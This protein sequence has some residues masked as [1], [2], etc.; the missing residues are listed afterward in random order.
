[1]TP[2]HRYLSLIRLFKFDEKPISVNNDDITD[3]VT[4]DWILNEAAAAK[5]VIVI[6]LQVWGLLNWPKPIH[7]RVCIIWFRSDRTGLFVALTSTISP[8]SGQCPWTARVDSVDYDHRID[9]FW[10]KPGTWYGWRIRPRLF[11]FPLRRV[12]KL[13]QS[14]CLDTQDGRMNLLITTKI[15]GNDR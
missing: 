11:S 9:S 2:W 3:Y 8:W 7:S 14:S 12:T 15:T 10:L 1:M 6:L 13:E 5:H 4:R